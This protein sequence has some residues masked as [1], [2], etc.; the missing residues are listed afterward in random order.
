LQSSRYNYDTGSEWG[1]TGVTSLASCALGARHS[2]LF[3]DFFPDF[4]V[5]F[6]RILTDS[7]ALLKN[8]GAT[9]GAGKGVM[10]RGA[11]AI[12]RVGVQSVSDYIERSMS[13]CQAKATP[14]LASTLAPSLPSPS[15]GVR[16]PVHFQTR[17]H[18]YGHE[19]IRRHPRQLPHRYGRIQQ[20]QMNTRAAPHAAPAPLEPHT[21][22]PPVPNTISASLWEDPAR[23]DEHALPPDPSQP[24]P[25]LK[26]LCHYLPIHDT[27]SRPMPSRPPMP[28]HPPM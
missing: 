10:Q 4:A 8:S 19:S 26:Q 6:D 18:V 5:N 28:A 15:G 3:L 9:G 12:R 17:G 2:V 21:P 7:C 25:G 1:Y 16:L 13:Y 24:M 14:V 23:S 27:P 20:G 11:R 22:P